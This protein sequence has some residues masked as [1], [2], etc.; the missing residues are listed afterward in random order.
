MIKNEKKS[1]LAVSALELPSQVWKIQ[2]QDNRPAELV[3][4]SILLEI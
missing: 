4:A 3:R 2:G 1:S